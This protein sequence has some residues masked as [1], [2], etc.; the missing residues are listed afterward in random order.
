MMAPHA[1]CLN[2]LLQCCIL[3]NILHPEAYCTL[4]FGALFMCGQQ[5]DC[6]ASALSSFNQL[7]NILVCWQDRAPHARLWLQAGASEKARALGGKGS[8]T[9]K[10]AVVGD[11]VGDPLKDTSGPSLNILIKLMAVESL[12]FAP[13]FQG[14]HP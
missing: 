7:M 11:T 1:S 2:A 13:F 8:D 4:C 3:Q 14:A 10:A 5:M 6:A 12:V 9:H